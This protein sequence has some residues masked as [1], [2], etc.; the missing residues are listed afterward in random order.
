MKYGLIGE[1]LSHS[2]SKDIHEQLADYKYELKEIARQDLD[3]F[4]QAKDFKAI[5]VTI[6]YK[7]DVIKYLDWKSEALEEIGACNAIVNRDGKL[8]GYN[9]D[10]AG[11]EALIK[12]ANVEIKGKTVIILGSGG[13]SITA[14]YVA[15]KLGCESLI[16]ASSSGK[17]GTVKYDDIPSDIEVIINTTPCGMYPNNYTQALSLNRF[18]SLKGVIDVVYNPLRTQLVIEA[19][20]RGI[21]AESGLYMLVAQ[22]F[23]GAQEFLGKKLDPNKI[24][25][26]YKDILKKK[27]NVVL[28]GMPTSGK[29]TSGKKL[30][31]ILNKQ[32]IDTDEVILK[33]IEGS[34]SDFIHKE[35]E[36]RFRDLETEVVK[37]SAKQCG[38]VIA[39]G[40]GAILREKNIDALRQNGVIYF[41]D[42]PL[43][44]LQVASDRPLSSSRDALTKM[45]SDRYNIYCGCADVIVEANGRGVAGVV[46]RIKKEEEK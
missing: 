23:Y 25:S 26:I 4:M 19:K 27:R 18:H 2:Y 15:K 46:N 42:R 40:G 35:G 33:M 6:P 45:F 37:E 21:P 5:N 9:F 1:K 16:V 22:A 41:L 30:S 10:A 43:S 11:L 29:S 3:S 8:Y 34:I 14:Q 44:N 36:Q 12:H 17:P 24:D 28:I 7:Q 31:S 38:S 32:F 39:T 20:K 13:T